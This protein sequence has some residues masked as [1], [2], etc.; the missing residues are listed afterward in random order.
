MKNMTEE[1]KRGSEIPVWR[2]S[3]FC[4]QKYLAFKWDWRIILIVRSSIDD[5]IL[6][7]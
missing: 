4:I 5:H 6:N 3:I 2:K 1:I 7:Q